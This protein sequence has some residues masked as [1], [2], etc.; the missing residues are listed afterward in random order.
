MSHPRLPQEISDYVVDLLQDEHE[1]LKQCRLISKSWIPRARMH[2]FR[3]IRFESPN[4]PAAWTKTFPDPANSPGS[5]ARCL[6][7]ACVGDVAAAILKNCD[8]FRSFSNV[9]RLQ[10]RNG[11]DGFILCFF[12]TNS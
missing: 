4:D 2:I 11:T 6:H 3:V 7:V 9:V 12:L 10:I 1:T 8:W 5:L